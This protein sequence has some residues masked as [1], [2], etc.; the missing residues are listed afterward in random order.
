MLEFHSKI[1]GVSAT[2]P[3]FG[4]VRIKPR[5]CGLDWARGSVC[6]PRGMIE[7]SWQQTGGA[8]A[9]QVKSPEKTPTEIVLPDG[10]IHHSPGGVWEIGALS[11]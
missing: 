7:V 2:A 10:T 11:S 8:F 5:A 3:G 6:T 9:L 1:L 4:A